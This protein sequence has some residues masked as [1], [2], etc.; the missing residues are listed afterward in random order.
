MLSFTEE[1][2][3]KAIYHL[4][5]NGSNAVSTNAISDILSTKPASVSDM[6]KKLSQKKVIS[7]IKYQGVNMTEEGRLLALRIIRKHR[8]WEVFLVKHLGFN[9][10]QVHDVAEELEHINSSLLIKR[11]DEF[12]GFPKFDPHGDPIP[13]EDGEMSPLFTV[14][15]DTLD[16]GVVAVV[17]SLNETSGEFLRHLDKLGINLGVKVKIMDVSTF[18]KSI[19]LQLSSDKNVM[20]SNEVAKNINVSAE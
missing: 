11:L 13:S 18:D 4:S 20:I 1:N 2:Y 3:L 17:T 15:L 10:D 6:L 16:A 19:E 7:Y 12:L 9:W 8:L 5:N 14:S